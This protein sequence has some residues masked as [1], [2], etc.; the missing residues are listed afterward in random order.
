MSKSATLKVK[1]L[2][3]LKSPGKDGKEPKVS[4]VSQIDGAPTFAIG[5]SATLPSSPA[6]LSPDPRDAEA[7]S[8]KKKGLRLPFKIKRKK[9]KRNEPE[10]GGGEVFFSETDEL[11]SFYSQRWDEHSICL[12]DFIL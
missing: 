12:S 4:A 11:D 6:P 2:F 1:G 8:P 7:V 9:S 3:K 10:P 5:K